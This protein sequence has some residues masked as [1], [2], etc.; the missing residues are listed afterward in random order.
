MI[1]VNVLVME[2]CLIPLSGKAVAGPASLQASPLNVLPVLDLE[3]DL[4]GNLWI[5][6]PSW[7]VNKNGVIG[8]GRFLK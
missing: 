5:K 7:N 2:A 8:Y 3:A 1:R 4:T 6:P